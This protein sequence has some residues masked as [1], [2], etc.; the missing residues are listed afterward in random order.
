LKEASVGEVSTIG[1]D[2][3]KTVFQA[4]GA[5]A[6]GAVVFRKKL[7]RDQVLAFFAGQPKCLVAMEAC[8]SAHFWSRE[9][10]ALG[11]KVRLIPPAYVKPF[12]K[13][14]KNDMADAEAI[15][16]ASQRPTM[17]FVEPKSAEA[18]GA[19]VVFRTRDLL[20]RQRTQLIN[21]LRG[22]M[23]EFGYVV[24]QGAG[25]VSKLIDLVGDPSSDLPAEARPVLGVIVESLQAVQAQIV[26]LDHEIAARAKADPVAKRLMTIPGVGPVVA[27]ALVALAP[28]G[29]DLPARPRLRRLARAHAEAALQRR[30]G[31]AGPH[32]ED[33]RAQLAAAADPRR[34]LGG[35]GRSS[36]RI[37]GQSLARRHAGQEAAHAGHGGAGQQDG[38]DRLGADGARRVLQSSGRGGVTA[39]VR[40]RREAGRSDGRYGATV[41]DG[42]GKT[43]ECPGASSAQKAVWTRS[44]ISIQASGSERPHQ[45][46]GHTEAPEPARSDLS[47]TSCIRRGVHTR[48]FASREEERPFP[49]LGRE[50]AADTERDH[51]PAQVEALMKRK[52]HREPP[53]Q[54]EPAERRL[55]E[56]IAGDA[57]LLAEVRT[58]VGGVALYFALSNN[59]LVERSSGDIVSFGLRLPAGM[60]AQLRGLGETSDD[61]WNRD[62]QQERRAAAEAATQMISALR[63]LGWVRAYP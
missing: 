44:A 49:R 31:A 14:Q 56:A 62:D 55:L 50:Q 48:T 40:G 43:S 61:F 10:A 29:I 11:H 39:S 21:A 7:R 27:T 60:V 37:T 24:R 36:R 5:D 59:R 46:A 15:C 63:R 34:Q 9:L 54:L 58:D 2:L 35:Q 3:A 1:L 42:I 52:R 8:A 30:Q 22:H 57:D 20:V 13:R 28:T 53:L 23:A 32:L 47:K 17:R 19:A 51:G 45:Q 41:R 16:E 33:G 18:Q 12:V 25:H 4:H 38:E 6:S 26:V